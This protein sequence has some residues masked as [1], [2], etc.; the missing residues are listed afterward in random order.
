MWRIRYL[1]EIE[2]HSDFD[3]ILVDDIQALSFT[4]FQLRKEKQLD[5]LDRLFVFWEKIKNK[6]IDLSP[7]WSIFVTAHGMLFKREVKS[8]AEAKNYAQQALDLIE[9]NHKELFSNSRAEEFISIKH[10]A[11]GILRVRADH[12]PYRNIGRNQK[13]EVSYGENKA[14]VA[15]FKQVK[16]DLAKNKC[17]LIAVLD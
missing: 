1:D 10:H 9:L 3:H 17:T 6:A 11:E 2:R 15:K 14:L 5:Q 13:V 4:A 7:Y 8:I 12:D 16:D